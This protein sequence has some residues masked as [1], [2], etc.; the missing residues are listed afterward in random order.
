MRLFGNPASVPVTTAATYEELKSATRGSS[1]SVHG[2]NWVLCI[3]VKG[4]YNFADSYKNKRW[5]RYAAAT[6]AAVT[7]GDY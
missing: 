3:L 6:S 2:S 4:V 7:K 1:C 5:Q